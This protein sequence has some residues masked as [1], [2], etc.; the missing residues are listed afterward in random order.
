MAIQ[1]STEQEAQKLKAASEITETVKMENKNLK[2]K[3]EW[4]NKDIVFKTNKLNE[5][6]DENSAK[7]NQNYELR[8]SMIEKDSKMNIVLAEKSSLEA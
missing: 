5:F 2:E 1:E 6:L 7:N 4:L 8:K 3:I